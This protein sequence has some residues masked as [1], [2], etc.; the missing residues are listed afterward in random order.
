MAA[1]KENGLWVNFLCFFLFIILMVLLGIFFGPSA[2]RGDE[3]AARPLEKEMVSF[4]KDFSECL[5]LF[6]NTDDSRK[7]L[8]QR[9]E[10]SNWA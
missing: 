9:L 1:G 2:V 5:Y 7:E 10:K 3:R 4:A 6:I 8:G